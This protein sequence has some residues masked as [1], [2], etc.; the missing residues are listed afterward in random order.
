MR[1]E[2][3]ETDDTH[4]V[5]DVAPPSFDPLIVLVSD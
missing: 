5:K 1:D 4:K 3:S 2:A